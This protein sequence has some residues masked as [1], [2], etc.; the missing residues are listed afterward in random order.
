VGVFFFFFF[1][2]EEERGGCV[3]REDEGYVGKADGG[4]GRA[5]WLEREGRALRAGGARGRGG[6]GVRGGVSPIHP[7]VF[8]GMGEVGARPSCES[9]Q[10]L[11]GSR[12]WNYASSP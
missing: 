7:I 3:L 9:R 1:S 10:L 6:G 4:E 12:G 8:K 11:V 5:C 2:S